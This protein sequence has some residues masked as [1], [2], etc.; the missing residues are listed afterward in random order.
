MAM[1]TRREF[2]LLAGAAAVGCV[3]RGT[4]ALA[5]AP[6][7]PPPVARAPAVG[8]SWRYAKHDYFTGFIVDT[9]IDRV[10]KIGQSVEI[11][12]HSEAAGDKP[13]KY[14]SWGERWWHEYMGTDANTART[15]TEVQKPWGMIVVDPH[16]SELQAFEKAIPLWP[17][18]LRP[19]WSTT[20]VTQYMI[21]DSNETMPSQLTMS[22]QRWES[23]TVPAGRFNAL[24]YYNIIDFRFTN[25]SER[26]A[27]LRQEYIWFAPEIGRWVVRESRGIFR[28]DVGTE[29]KESSYRWELLSWT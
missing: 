22:A 28:E 13:I 17:T 2:V 6:G 25:V 20:V 16:W 12:S 9:Q 27:A 19:G 4:T 15:P 1:S 10:S 8:Q 3:A 14:P 21:P 29:V 5:A 23:I 18:Q 11:E 7:G 26:D 24:R